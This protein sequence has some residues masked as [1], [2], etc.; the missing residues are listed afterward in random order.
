MGVDNHG[1]A[2][3]KYCGAQI[4]LF[5]IFNRDMGGLARS[6]RSKH[7]RACKDRTPKQRLAW[8]KK[9]ASKDPIKDSG[10]TVDL[11]HEGFQFQGK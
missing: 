8:A 2:R 11:S 3:C 7:E 4:H 5:T 1:C 9:Y 6:W 10:V